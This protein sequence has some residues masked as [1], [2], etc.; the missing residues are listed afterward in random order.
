[1]MKQKKR[2]LLRAVSDVARHVAIINHDV[3]GRNSVDPNLGSLFLP[4]FE[5][6]A[7]G[8]EHT[9]AFISK[10]NVNTDEGLVFV[11]KSG[12]C[13]RHCRADRYNCVGG[14]EYLLN[15]KTPAI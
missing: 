5:S 10:P 2:L 11:S 6:M 13:R 8:S 3:L 15:K 7:D 9:L 14:R 12:Q 1:M 4:G